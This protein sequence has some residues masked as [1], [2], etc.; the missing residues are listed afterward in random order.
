M[1]ETGEADE[2]INSWTSDQ[3]Q[4]SHL[5]LEM[6]L[7]TPVCAKERWGRLKTTLNAAAT[8][9]KKKM[10]LD[11]G[12]SFLRK[13][14]TRHQGAD[15]VAPELVDL[16]DGN[17]F[18]RTR[19]RPCWPPVLYPGGSVMFYWLG[20]V[21]LALLYN[22]WTCIAREAFREIQNGYVVWYGLDGLCDLIYLLDIFAQFRTGYLNQGLLVYESSKLAKNYMHSKCFVLDIVSLIP[23]D[24]L[25]FYLGPHALLRF[26]RF[27]KVYRGLR[28]MQLYESRTQYPN[29]LRV[30]NLTHILFLG[31]HWFAAFYYLISEV[32]NFSGSW[33]YPLPEGDFA[34][35]TRKYLVSLHWST[36]T[37]TTIGDLPPP[38]TNWQ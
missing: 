37:L 8:V 10:R 22:L 11:R 26:P 9:Q 6:K 5:S 21:T 35:V 31:S 17:K 33:S 18:Y 34:S 2:T 23:L 7:G 3:D 30:L 13:F 36:L 1:A 27:L 38:E 15:K 16:K 20:L 4:Q 25:Q 24:F 32:E 14:S 19:V 12:D 29:L 28:F